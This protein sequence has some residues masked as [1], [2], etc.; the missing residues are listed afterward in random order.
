MHH[1]HSWLSWSQ[2]S[3]ARC[4]TIPV[5]NAMFSCPSFILYVLKWTMI[6]KLLWHVAVSQSLKMCCTYYCYPV[7]SLCCLPSPL[8]LGV[9]LAVRKCSVSAQVIG[10]SLRSESKRTPYVKTASFRP[11]FFLWPSATLLTIIGASCNSVYEYFTY[12]CLPK[13]IFVENPLKPLYEYF[14]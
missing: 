14:S 12:I 10:S 8:E 6:G 1:D 13:L 9:Q 7:T 5:H 11:S 3:V 4:V 2:N